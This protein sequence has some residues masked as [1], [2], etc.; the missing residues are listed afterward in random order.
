MIRGTPKF[1]GLTVAKITVS[2][3]GPTLDFVGEAAFTNSKTGQTHG[4]TKNQTWS[5]ETIEKLRELRALMEVDLGAV[6]LDGGGEVLAG[7]AALPVKGGLSV[8]ESGLGEHVGGGDIPS[9]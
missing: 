2:F 1:D 7:P 3:L 9:I 8:P 6:H 5:K 4:W